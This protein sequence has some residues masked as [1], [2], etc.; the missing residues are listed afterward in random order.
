MAET[1]ADQ[2]RRRLLKE[3]RAAIE[4]TIPEEKEKASEKLGLFSLLLSNFIREKGLALCCAL[5][6]IR[7]SRKEGSG[8][9]RAVK[10]VVDGKLSLRF[11]RLLSMK[12][13]RRVFNCFRALE[14]TSWQRFFSRKCQRSLSSSKMTTTTRCVSL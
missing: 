6:D 11:S 2:P 3:D 8:A 14:P 5:I 7:K 13:G 10:D 1:I 4:D 12:I 9:E